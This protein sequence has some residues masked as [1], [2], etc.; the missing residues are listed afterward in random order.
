MKKHVSFATLCA[1]A[2]LTVASNAQSAQVLSIAAISQGR[3]TASGLV[4]GFEENYQTGDPIGGGGGGEARSYFEFDLSAVSAPI[5]SARLLLQNP[6][7]GFQS[8]QDAFETLRIGRTDSTAFN[9]LNSGAVFGS[10]EVS[11]ADNNSTIEIDF[12]QAGIDAINANADTFMLGGYIASLNG[13]DDREFV[14]G[15]SGGSGSAARLDLT[16]VPLPAA[17]W[18][19]LPAV[20]ILGLSGTPRAGRR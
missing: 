4:V 12:N 14:F 18:L 5:T 7:D 17:L 19:L 1:L 6:I 3:V 13:L 11:A 10:R 16:A 8:S 15:F 20:G 2:L 9:S